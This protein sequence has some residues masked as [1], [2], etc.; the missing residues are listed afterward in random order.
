M[1]EELAVNA[2]VEEEVVK[3]EPAV[4]EIVEDMVKEE[5]AVVKA[6][7][8]KEEPAIVEEEVVKEEPAVNEIVEDKVVKDE[9][10]VNEI[11]EEEVM[12]EQ[13]A[14]E[15]MVSSDGEIEPSL[16]EEE[17]ETET[18]LAE[19]EARPVTDAEETDITEITDA[20]SI[21]VNFEVVKA[22]FVAA[23]EAETEIQA[24]NESEESIALKTANAG[25]MF[26]IEVETEPEVD[27]AGNEFSDDKSEKLDHGTES[28]D[29]IE[30]AKDDEA[31]KVAEHFTETYIEAQRMIPNETPINVALEIGEKAS[32]DHT[33]SVETDK[34]DMPNQA[35]YA[36][37]EATDI[38][39]EEVKSGRKKSAV[40]IIAEE[41]H[42]ANRS[43]SA[44]AAATSNY[45]EMM[46]E[47]L[48]HD[49]FISDPSSHN[50]DTEDPPEQL[51]ASR[52]KKKNKNAPRSYSAECIHAKVRAD[53]QKLGSRK[54]EAKDTT[55]KEIDVKSKKLQ[56]GNAD[57]EMK[58]A[59]KAK[60]MLKKKRSTTQSTT[61]SA[62]EVR[63]VLLAD[64]SKIELSM[65]LSKVGE[66]FSVKKS[67]TKGAIL[68]P[69]N[70]SY[71]PDQEKGRRTDRAATK[72]RQQG[73]RQ[74]HVEEL[75]ALSKKMSSYNKRFK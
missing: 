8:V 75:R 64:L 46:S 58:K 1:K 21:T 17:V 45:E 48:K 2:I 36:L 63:S 18:I 54:H 68:S 20:E 39:K 37:E 43:F 4:N 24:I 16:M 57:R 70:K 12:K 3:E 55:P 5:P 42:R 56:G 32:L 69:E 59:L 11:V 52:G 6:E 47:V 41:L 19:T 65:P 51:A 27:S 53:L 40:S 49:H 30:P 44:A 33:I 35:G 71:H 7:V 26:P 61:L 72:L 67:D 73:K 38:T 62:E 29:K 15:D 34:T 23:I 13:P 14:A 74:S 9:P 28:G 50:Q 10:T 22:G 66:Q 60:S 31:H 25:D